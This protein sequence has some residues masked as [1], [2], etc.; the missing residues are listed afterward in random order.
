MAGLGRRWV[1]RHGS[2]GV[3][4]QIGAWAGFGVNELRARCS[5]KSDREAVVAVDSDDAERQIDKLFVGELGI[6]PLE[7]VVRY[8]ALGD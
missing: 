5:T 4:A 8:L 3:A 1:G 6:S 7:H 2:T